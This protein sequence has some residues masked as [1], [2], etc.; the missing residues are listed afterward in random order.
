MVSAIMSNKIDVSKLHTLI[1]MEYSVMPN[2]VPIPPEN[3]IFDC[4]AKLLRDEDQDTPK[5]MQL[6]KFSKHF[7]TFGH[8]IAALQTWVGVKSAFSNKGLWAA[9]V[10][11]YIGQITRLCAIYGWANV[12]NYE[13]AFYTRYYTLDDPPTLWAMEDA[14]FASLY[15]IHIPPEKRRPFGSH[16][17]NSSFTQVSPT[18]L[19]DRIVDVDE[20]C[21]RFNSGTLYAGKCKYM[22]RCNFD[23]TRCSGYH[24][25]VNCNL[26]PA[27]WP[28]N[29]NGQQ[30]NKSTGLNTTFPHRRRENSPPQQRR[31]E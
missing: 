22:H 17:Q 3:N 7:P 9:S 31:R 21:R 30:N 13:V 16:P 1:P 25:A 8:W 26:N 20:P 4:F 6:P 29:S 28:R 5:S 24:S 18:P 23:T 15:L 11:V 19:N 10:G 27:K 12:R 2:A 14:K